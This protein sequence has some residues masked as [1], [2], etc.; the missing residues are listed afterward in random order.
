MSNFSFSHS[1]FY[2]FANPFRLTYYQMTNFRLVQTER[3]CRRQF[4]IWWKWQK[5]FQTG[6]KHCGK[7]RNCSLWAIFPFP[8]VFSKGLFPRGVIVWEWVKY[9]DKHVLRSWLSSLQMSIRI[10]INLC[11]PKFPLDVWFY[12]VSRYFPTTQFSDIRFQ[13]NLV[14]TYLFYINWETSSYN[15]YKSL[16]ILKTV[17]WQIWRHTCIMPHLGF[18]LSY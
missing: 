9:G 6:R 8:T 1:V 17:P 5:V 14:S 13:D 16:S 12:P 10:S 18:L 3:V 15:C 2:Q 7:R 11:P 4:Q